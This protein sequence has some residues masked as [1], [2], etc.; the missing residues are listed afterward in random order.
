MIK[1]IAGV[2]HKMFLLIRCFCRNYLQFSAP[3]AVAQNI[4]GVAKEEDLEDVHVVDRRILATIKITT[5]DYRDNVFD[6]AAKADPVALK[7]SSCQSSTSIILQLKHSV[8]VTQ[9][10]SQILIAITFTL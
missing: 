10:S 9:I 4:G 3:K 1:L 5:V 8:A 7:P 2:S 6:A